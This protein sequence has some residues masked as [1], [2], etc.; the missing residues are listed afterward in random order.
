L[1]SPSAPASSAASATV[2]KS[3]P[4]AQQS[5]VFSSELR[6]KAR[7]TTPAAERATIEL[8]AGRA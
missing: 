3:V 5:V 6:A 8:R 7:A 4:L 2:K 1:L